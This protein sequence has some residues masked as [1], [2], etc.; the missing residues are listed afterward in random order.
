M[1]Q[2][3]NIEPE[4]LGLEL[5]E[6]DEIGLEAQRTILRDLT[7]LGVGLAMDDLGSG[8]SNLQRLSSFPFSAIKLDRGLFLHVMDRP[9]ETLSIIATLIQ[10]GRDLGMHVVVEGL[11]NQSLVE[12]ATILG[13]PLG[14][15]YHFARPMPPEQCLRW[16][17]SFTLPSPR[18]L[19][20]TPLGALAYHWQF[21]RLAAPH[22]SEL[23]HCP[24]TRFV[25]E[26]EAPQQVRTWHAQ[27]HK[28]PMAHISSN[29]FLIDWL[30]AMIRDCS[31]E[32]THSP[33]LFPRTVPSA[34]AAQ[35]P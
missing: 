2:S 27:H 31:P 30:T 32:E 16:S 6:S 13:A 35:Q 11:E 26:T 9:V 19:I 10:L 25:A 24:L 34:P 29:H 17:E 21:D 28:I 8:Y 3:R 1:L 15:G 4:R 20:Q 18:P 12:A 7:D 14:Q 33:A 5:L 23:E 22:P